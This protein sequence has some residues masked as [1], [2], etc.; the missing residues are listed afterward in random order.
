MGNVTTVIHPL[1]QHK[2]TH[3][4][5]KTTSTNGFR[6]LLREIATLLC[7]EV[8]RD[9]SLH[10][11]QIE[12]PM[13][14]MQAQVLR[15]FRFISCFLRNYICHPKTRAQAPSGLRPPPAKA[16]RLKSKR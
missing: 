16:G 2:L 14:P 4:R 3:M 11:V 7:Y 10:T 9:L 12:T 6:Q 8:T 15:T 5:D 13:M 1:V